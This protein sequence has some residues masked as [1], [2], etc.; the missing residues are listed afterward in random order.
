[1]VIFYNVWW[2]KAQ[3]I[4]ALPLNHDDFSRELIRHKYLLNLPGA[5][6]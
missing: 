3:A 2:Y 5:G 4:L 1:M 6:N